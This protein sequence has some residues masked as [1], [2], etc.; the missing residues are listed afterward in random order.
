[1]E[2]LKHGYIL[3][4]IIG[5]AFFGIP[6]LALQM[7]WIPSL[8]IGG[9][10]FG[11]GTL[12]FRNK[13]KKL[14]ISGN[15]GN[16]YDIIKEAREKTKEL[17]NLAMCLE[18]PTLIENVKE[19]SRISN[20]IINTVSKKP[21][22][23]K[24]ANNFLNYYL[25]VT[26]K[27]IRRYDEIENQKLGTKESKEFMVS[28][29]SMIKKVREAFEKQLASMYQSDMIDTDAEIKV[30]ETML[31]SDGFLADIQIKEDKQE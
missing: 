3:S 29:Q 25:P 20:N 23:L 15:Q 8:V 4:A 6:Y 21:E 12:V 27:I 13:Q 5:G 22:K 1:M 19:I 17:E 30:F 24:N 28:I 2:L 7:N 14:D 16:L 11:A 31:R 18:E 9:V 10:A 26:I